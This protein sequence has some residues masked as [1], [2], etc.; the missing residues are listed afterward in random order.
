MG[1]KVTDSVEEKG[2][3]HMEAVGGGR[4]NGGQR[5]APPVHVSPQI[6]NR[7]L[8]CAC[9]APLQASLVPGLGA[10]VLHTTCAAFCAGPNKVGGPWSWGP[11]PGSH[12][13]WTRIQQVSGCPMGRARLCWVQ[14]LHS[15]RQGLWAAVGVEL[16]PL[17]KWGVSSFCRKGGG[18]C[19]KRRERKESGRLPGGESHLR[20]PF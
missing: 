6:S 12:Q 2:T 16:T 7:S 18:C 19:G 17:R 5:R 4:E 1:V 3:F 20:G 14:Q 15:R 8:L 13:P 9:A 10:L 11:R